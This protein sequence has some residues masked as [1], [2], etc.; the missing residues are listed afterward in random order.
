MLLNKMLSIFIF[1]KYIF[2]FK[3]HY[4]FEYSNEHNINVFE[5]S[6]EHNINQL[7]GVVC[8]TMHSKS[9]SKSIGTK[10]T[11]MR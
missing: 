1:G 5:Y 3:K 10:V 2:K 7:S 6:N 9:I 4:L 8:G 11:L